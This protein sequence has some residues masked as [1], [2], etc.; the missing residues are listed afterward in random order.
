MRK[1]YQ[2]CANVSGSAVYEHDLARADACV[3]K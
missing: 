3:F 2:V 1:L